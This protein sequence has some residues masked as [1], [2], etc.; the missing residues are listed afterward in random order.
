MR[1]QIHIFIFDAAP[2]LFNKDIVDPVAFTVHAD[3]DAIGVERAGKFVAGELTA[4]IRIENIRCPVTCDHFL[5]G[6]YAKAGVHRVRQAPAQYF[7]T[8]PVHHCHQIE[9]ALGLGNITDIGRPH[10]V[11]PGNCKTFSS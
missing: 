3:L 9:K 7:A 2:E 8:M 11:R 6:F 1:F 5:Q 10:Q 4:L